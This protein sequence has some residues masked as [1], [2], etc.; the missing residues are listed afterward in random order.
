[1]VQ[2]IVLHIINE[3]DGTIR[4]TIIPF[5]TIDRFMEFVVGKGYP[6]PEVLKDANTVIFFKGDNRQFNVRIEYVKETIEQIIRI[7]KEQ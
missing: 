7:I 4:K 1:M 6:K 3:L 5:D 2:F